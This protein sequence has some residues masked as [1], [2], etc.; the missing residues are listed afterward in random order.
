MIWG[1]LFNA[2][3][4]AVNSFLSLLGIENIPWLFH[5]TW[6]RINIV[7]LEVWRG[8][9][10]V[11]VIFLIALRNV[12]RDF[13]EAAEIDGASSTRQLF[14]ISLPMIS[15]TLFF[16]IV[17]QTIFSLQIFDSVQ[18]LTRG[19]PGFSTTTIGLHIYN[20]AFLF[21]NMGYGATIAIVLF[22]IM[23]IFTA[24]QFYIAKKWVHY[25]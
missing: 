20:T 17:T 10:F 9:G 5:P 13:Y 23:I 16:I 6:A 25:N 11:F 7:M 21:R 4:G 8:L 1:F 18:L 14:S 2:Q 24:T 3:F 22:F 15:P 12:P 19:G